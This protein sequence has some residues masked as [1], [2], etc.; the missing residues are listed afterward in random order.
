MSD[1]R[2]AAFRQEPFKVHH[3]DSCLEFRHAS[4]EEWLELLGSLSYPIS[5]NKLVSSDTWDE[6]LTRLADGTLSMDDF[7]YLIRKGLGEAA[8]RPWWEAE[9]ILGACLEE[10]RLLGQVLLSGLDPSRITLAAFTAAVWALLTKGL[11]DTGLMKLES[12]ILVPPPDADLNDMP[13]DED[14]TELARKLRSA[15]GIR[16]G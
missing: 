5:L 16:V 13:A 10:P 6:A 14:F 11:D 9:R 4:A 2:R 7:R 3:Q 15:P 1:L 8:A 12:Q